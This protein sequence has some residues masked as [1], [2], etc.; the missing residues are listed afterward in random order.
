MD[1]RG[2]FVLYAV[3]VS[4]CVALL[5]WVL[6]DVTKRR[7]RRE[8]GDRVV[9]PKVSVCSVMVVVCNFLICV[10]HVGFAIFGYWKLRIV[11]FKS[12]IS[13]VTWV[14]V[15]S[16][17]VYSNNNTSHRKW[18]LLLLLWWLFSW[19]LQSIS[20]FFVLRN[21]QTSNIVDLVSLPL[22]TLLCINAIATS[23]SSEEQSDLLKQ[24]FLENYEEENSVDD[25]FSEAGI[26]SK[27]TFSW[28]NPL[29][30]KGRIQKLELPHIPSLPYT[31]TAKYASSLL[32]DSLR[33]KKMGAGSSLPTAIIYALWKPL[34]INA[35]FAGITMSIL[36]F[37]S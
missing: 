28:L 20:V 6:A 23:F 35:L 24:P 10:L 5:I 12:G 19:I 25:D 15:T 4:F 21:I 9:V 2:D 26:W 14:L 1:Y 29:F 32:E 7:R 16:I 22:L 18:P 37:S 8:E 33:K 17:T 31:E 13:V 34:A 3:N 36:L 27:L 30:T 11:T